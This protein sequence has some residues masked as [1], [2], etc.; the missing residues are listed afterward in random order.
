M[1]GTAERARYPAYPIRRFRVNGVAPAIGTASDSSSKRTRFESHQ[2]AQEKIVRVFFSSQKCCAD[3]LSVEVG[4]GVF[5]YCC[6]C[7]CR[8][9][10]SALRTQFLRGC[11]LMRAA[12]T[13]KFLSFLHSFH[14]II[15]TR[16][17]DSNW[18]KVNVSFTQRAGT[19]QQRGQPI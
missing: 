13:C 14:S 8:V 12:S 15:Y 10:F 1:L 19:E 5:C 4:G 6:C 7:S 3:S 16:L 17:P 11:F 18:L 2:R 9:C